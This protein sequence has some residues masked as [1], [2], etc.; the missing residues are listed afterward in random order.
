HR[1]LPMLWHTGPSTRPTDLGAILLAHGLTHVEDE[2]GMAADLLAL[3]E[4]VAPLPAALAFTPVQDT[5][6]L[7]AWIDV[8]LHPV[9]SI[10]L[11]ERFLAAIAGLG[12]AQERPLRHYLGVLD[13]R[14]VATATLFF[15][16]GVVSVQHVVTH[17]AFRRRGIG[18]AMTLRALRAA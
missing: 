17:S 10:E 4:E 9:P 13:G 18:A 6:A 14:P 15:G 11:R 12:F 5:A 2:P 8:W 1:H 16:A 7:R 3:D